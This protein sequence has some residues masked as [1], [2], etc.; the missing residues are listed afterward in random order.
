MGGYDQICSARA[1]RGIAR[2]GARRIVDDLARGG[3]T[4]GLR[5]HQPPEGFRGQPGAHALGVDRMHRRLRRVA[6][7][8]LG[9]LAGKS[10]GG[11]H[12]MLE[13][14]VDEQRLA[15]ILLAEHGHAHRPGEALDHASQ[16]PVGG[17]EARQG[18]ARAGGRKCG[19]D[20][21]QL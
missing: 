21:P 12:L 13:Q 2:S 17:R 18:P 14:I 15:G 9:R 10:A 4:R 5:L 1:C 3:G 16:R 6:D 11:Q 20:R 8:K 19:A 7:Q